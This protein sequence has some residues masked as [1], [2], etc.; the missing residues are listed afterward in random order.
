[1]EDA[2][3]VISRTFD[4]IETLSKAQEPMNLTDIAK[5]TQINKST[6]YRLLQAMYA[7]HYV[8]K[9]EKGLYSIGIKLVEVVSCHINGLELQTEAKPFLSSLR[10][11]LNLT[12]HLGILEA[13]EVIYI[14]KMDLY[15]TTRLYSQVGYR[16]PAY[17]SSM[18]KCLLSCLSGEELDETLNNCKFD[19]Y[20]KN[21]IT[22]MR[23]FKNYLK[24]IRRQGWAM[25]D[26]EYLLGHRCVGAPIFDYRG[27]AVASISASGTISQISDD[28]LPMIIEQVKDSALQISKRMGYTG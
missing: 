20:T 7:R 22:N 24:N 13:H 2:V 16:S 1:M 12:V 21:T 6:V 18:G 28:K 4:I 26:E 25:D 17:C 19:S 10:A 9:S 5:N 27:D 14:E 3:R 8:E 23:D 11:E 15:P